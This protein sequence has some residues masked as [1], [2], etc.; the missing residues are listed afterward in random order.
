VGSYSC[1]HC[2]RTRRRVMEDLPQPPSPQMVIVIRWG[3]ED[4]LCLCVC[5]CVC[6]CLVGGVGG[7]GGG[8]VPLEVCRRGIAE[9]LVTFKVN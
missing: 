4:I 3:S 5:V 7:W 2:E 6:V 1:V 9:V 8:D